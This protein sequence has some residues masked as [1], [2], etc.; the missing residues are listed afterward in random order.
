MGFF[1]DTIFPNATTYPLEF[2]IQLGVVSGY[3]MERKFGFAPAIPTTTAS[4]Y[5]ENDIYTYPAAATTMTVSSS[6]ANDTSA[7]TG[8]QTVKV[9][10]LNAT[11]D[12]ISETITMNGQTGVTTSLSYLRVHR[13]Q[14]VTAGSGE[15][16]AGNIYMGTGAITAGKPAVVHGEIIAGEGQTLQAIYCVPNA[17]TAYVVEA[18]ISVGTG[19]AFTGGFYVRAFGEDVFQIKQKII[20]SESATGIKVNYFS[21]SQKS[22]TEF[23]GSVD[24]GTAAVS[25]SY[26]MILKDN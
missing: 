13:M 10:G 26:A 9:T 16:N 3:S 1:H 19:K 12:E 20:L 18:S 22:D 24:T 17:K 2:M 6:D 5:P 7:G 21:I 8:A 15:T 11:Y 14:A 23:R 4:V 25:A